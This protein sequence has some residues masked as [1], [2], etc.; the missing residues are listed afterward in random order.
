MFYVQRSDVA[1]TIFILVNIFF[2]EIDS[3]TCPGIMINSSEAQMM[4]DYYVKSS[5]DPR[6]T[7]EF[8]QTDL[9]EGP[10]PTVAAFSS[11][12]PNLNSLKNVLKTDLIAP[13]TR[14][15]AAWPP[16]KQAVMVSQAFWPKAQVQFRESA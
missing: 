5:E 3:F 11:R 4:I 8:Q 13:G 7:I 10:T 2:K 6:A 16:N 14:V 12:G 9:G 15:L 1:A